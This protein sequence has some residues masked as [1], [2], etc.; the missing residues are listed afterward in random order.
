[1]DDS[2]QKRKEALI[3]FIEGVK[4]KGGIQQAGL[5]D[6]Y[7]HFECRDK[8]GNLKWVDGF[9]NAITDEGLNDILSKYYKGSAYTAAHYVGLIDNTPTPT[10]AN[11]D[12]AAQITADGSGTNDWA[13]LSEYDESARQTITW[14]SVAAQSV[15]NT[16]SKAVFTI[17][18]TKTIYG[19]FVATVSTKDGATGV[20]LGHG[21]LST[22]RSL[23][24]DDTLTI[25]VTA[26]MARPS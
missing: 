17:S 9:W 10:L 3:N 22:P 19:A 23:A 26:T 18:A 20:L 8:D 5:L 12:T 13:E 1:M 7:Y 11:G 16:G 24:D 15:D 25:T 6:H 21:A 4:A 14:G 2:I